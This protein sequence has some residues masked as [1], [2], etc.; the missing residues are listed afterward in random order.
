MPLRRSRRTGAL[1]TLAGV[2][3]LV[4]T[5]GCISK[6]VT[7]IEPTA[8]T[9]LSGRWNDTDS[10]L[11]ANQLVEQTL[12]A[13]WAKRYTDTHGGEAPAV[14]VGTF[15]NR[16]MEHIAVGTF[17]KDIERALISTGAARVV[18]SGD[19]RA[20]MRD[21]RK[22]QQQNARADTR[23][24]QGQELG[25]RY[26]LAG[27]LQ[28]IEDV[29]GRERVIFYQVDA[30]LIDLETNTKV[31]VGQHKIKKYVERARFGL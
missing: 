21:E 17:V 1:R 18:A 19:Q 12:D 4:A 29:D 23:A 8:V 7:R 24:R 2:L 5:S 28:A 26:M 11:V 31:W 22:D 20:E 9:D 6:R 25:A 27:D 10:R 30:A 16:T 13:G 14:V 15:T 3:L